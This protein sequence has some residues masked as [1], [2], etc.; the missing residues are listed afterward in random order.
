ML[1]MKKIAH[2][3][4][5]VDKVQAKKEFLENNLPKCFNKFEKILQ[6]QDGA[7]LVNG[8]LTWADI[9]VVDLLEKLEGDNYAGPS[10]LKAYPN[11]KMLK[12]GVHFYPGIKEWI[13]IRPKD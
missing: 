7:F 4:S 2:S 1:E 8:K 5:E 11:L 6:S 9:V 3:K 13:E 10:L 12:L